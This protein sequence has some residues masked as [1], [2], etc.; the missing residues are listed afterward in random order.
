[1]AN[2]TDVLD[3]NNV[4]L[5]NKGYIKVD[6]VELAELNSIEIKITPETKTMGIMNSPTKAEIIVGYTGTITMELHKQY[7]RFKPALLECA[8]KQRPF[9]FTLECTVNS[10]NDDGEQESIYID[11]CWFKGELTLAQLKAD[12]EFLNEKFECGFSIETA[13]FTDTIDDGE[14]WKSINYKYKR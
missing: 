8:K 4:L 7:S 11:N 10:P 2:I 13:E 14:D 5:S 6:Q 1:M 12:G 3:P 9:N